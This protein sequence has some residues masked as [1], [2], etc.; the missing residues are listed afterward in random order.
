MNAGRRKCEARRGG[1]GR[2][3][4]ACEL[5]GF[6]TAAI[7]PAGENLVRYATISNDGRHAG[8]GG[9]GAVMGAKNVKALSVR[10]AARCPCARA[11]TSCR[12][13]SI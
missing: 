10:G 7:G 13:S 6:R 8:R 2:P 9:L 11:S 3:A 4:A 1:V 12:R 5:E